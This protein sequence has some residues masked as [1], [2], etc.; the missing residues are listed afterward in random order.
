MNLFRRSASAAAPAAELPDPSEALKGLDRTLAEWLQL[1]PADLAAVR[2]AGLFLREEADAIVEAFYD[3]SFRFRHFLEALERAQSTRARISAKQKAYFLSLLEGRIDEEYLRERWAI[4]A[5]HARLDVRPEWYLGDY[6]VY[7]SL[8]A[9]RLARRW[10]RSEE[11]LPALNAFVKLFMLDAGQTV[12]AY[13]ADTVE[14]AAE[15][16]RLVAE[17]LDRTISLRTAAHEIAGAVQSIAEGAHRQFS[18]I[19]SLT[20]E[21]ES[22]QD[23][24][25]ELAGGAQEQ[26]AAVEQAGVDFDAIAEAVASVAEESRAVAGAL[27][28]SAMLA[29]EGAASVGEALRAFGAAKESVQAAAAEVVE[30]GQRGQEIG[31]IVEI[32]EDVASQTN[33]LA[34]NAAIEAARAGEQGRG[35]AVV[36]D[37]VRALAERTAAS[38]KQV[39]ELVAAVQQG[40]GRAVR[41]IEQAVEQVGA[42]EARAQAVGQALER[43]VASVSSAADQGHRIEGLA[44]ESAAASDRGRAQT[45]KVREVAQRVM[46]LAERMA[47]SLE[48]TVASAREVSA[49]AEGSVAATEEVSASVE[50]VTAQLGEL[51]QMAE[52]LRQSIREMESFAAKLTVAKKEGRRAA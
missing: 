15:P 27:Q 17:Q 3:H 9:P 23:G 5:A 10:K 24:V 28:E 16:V 25:R 37:N 29:R 6:A 21:L 4:G 47:A 32:I 18:Q 31:A 19:E 11:L 50:E 12:N 22:V 48:R 38:T 1:G 39:A 33:L 30:L 40:T 7:F 34:L 49:A 52:Q 26:I 42:G 35:F 46:E 20:R 36:A 2:R 8:V 43:I 14:V 51:A 13:L 41:S 44:R 45:A